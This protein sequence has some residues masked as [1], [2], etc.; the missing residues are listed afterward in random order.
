MDYIIALVLIVIVVPLLFVLLSRRGKG[1][2][3]IGEQP[4]SSGMTVMEPASDQPA[5]TA[6]ST[7][8]VAPGVERRLP[9]G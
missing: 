7:N 9:P 6:D 1:A 3:G 8:Q 5:P 4:H 2:G